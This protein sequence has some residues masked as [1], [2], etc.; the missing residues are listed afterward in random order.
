MLMK[1]AKHDRI[2]GEGRLYERIQ[3][4]ELEEK[5][6]WMKGQEAEK[7]D[8]NGEGAVMM[9]MGMGGR[10]ERKVDEHSHTL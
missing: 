7:C 4:E 8:S 9:T 2:G 3:E 6:A 5:D 1:V 10:E